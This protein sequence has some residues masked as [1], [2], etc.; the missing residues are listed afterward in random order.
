MR[1]AGWVVDFKNGI[2]GSLSGS[3]PA[4]WGLDRSALQDRALPQRGIRP[5]NILRS[6]HGARDQR[7]QSQLSQSR[8]GS[9]HR[10]LGHK[11]RTMTWTR[12]VGTPHFFNHALAS[13]PSRLAGR[14]G[15]A[16]D[17]PGV[18]AFVVL[19]IEARTLP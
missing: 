15:H 16:A 9:H 18:L 14:R 8:A 17:G 13:L 1:C 12:R 5:R 2:R 3:A 10:D 11:H 19:V 6:D 7:N 4:S